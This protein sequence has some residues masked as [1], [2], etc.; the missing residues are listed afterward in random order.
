MEERFFRCLAS[1]SCSINLL[2]FRIYLRTKGLSSTMSA[3]NTQ[4]GES[5]TQIAD[6]RLLDEAISFS[7]LTDDL[8]R[9]E[10]AVSRSSNF[11]RSSTPRFILFNGYTVQLQLAFADI[12]L[13]IG[14]L[15]R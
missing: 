9:A 15:S 5:Y 1:V 7:R 13:C 12:S 14:P 2:A 6:Y 3:L 4:L 11:C 8:T 10:I